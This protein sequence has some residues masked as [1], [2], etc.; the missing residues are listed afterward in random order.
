M[1][2]RAVAVADRCAYLARAARGVEAVDVSDATNSVWMSDDLTAGPA[3]D[4]ALVGDCVVVAAGDAGLQ[5]FQV[6]PRLY[7]PLGAPILLGGMMTLSGPAMDGVRLQKATN[8]VSATWED[9]VG[10]EGTN[11]VSL[12]MTMAAAF[13]RL[14]KL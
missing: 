9:V 1:G 14:V 2:P 11:T 12:P 7:P 3:E 8:L 13:F 4:V 10:S 5:V 6:R